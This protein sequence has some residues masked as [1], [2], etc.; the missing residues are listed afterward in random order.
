MADSMKLNI[1]GYKFKDVHYLEFN[2]QAENV[3]DVGK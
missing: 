2:N 3:N 1:C